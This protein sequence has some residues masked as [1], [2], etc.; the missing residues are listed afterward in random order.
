[1]DLSNTKL[2]RLLQN[3]KLVSADEPRYYLSLCCI[4]KD[5]NEYLAEWLEYHRKIGVEHFYIYDNGSKISVDHTIRTLNLSDYVTITYI[6]GRN[7]HI[8]AYG[9]C[10]RRFGNLSQWIG[11]IDIDEFIV[12]KTGNRDLKSF[13]GGYENFGGLGISWLIFGSNGHVKKPLGSQ[14]ESFTKRSEVTF[15]A[16]KHIKSIVQPKYTK[17]AHKS[18]SFKYKPGFYCVNENYLPIEDAFSE[19]SIDKIQLNHYYCRSLEEYH[20]KIKRGISDT[21]R[22]RLLDE[23]YYHDA[24]SN[25]VEDDAILDVVKRLDND[26]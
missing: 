13:L 2:W 11:F 4:V 15:L 20:Q 21:K 3:F 7:K 23:F 18:H 5:E 8:R 10:L 16:N 26:T 9:N 17:S 19:P 22:P 1:M 14:M 6:P 24:E 12:P 25:K